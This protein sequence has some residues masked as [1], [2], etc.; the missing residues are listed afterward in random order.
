MNPLTVAQWASGVMLHLA[1]AAMRGI[2]LA[3][4][5][6]LVLAGFRVRLLTIQ[7]AVWKAVLYAG[8]AMPLLASLL[9]VL[10]VHLRIP[11]EHVTAAT[12]TPSPRQL[13]EHDGA[14]FVERVQQSGRLVRG[15][16]T[17]RALRAVSVSVGTVMDWRAGDAAYS[18]S[19]GKSS[20]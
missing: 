10:P 19:A 8:L 13:V 18:Y 6:A 15:A 20:G 14:G 4:L 12:P 9:P 17:A 1:D 2:V 3:C 16:R 7:L 5:A 11:L